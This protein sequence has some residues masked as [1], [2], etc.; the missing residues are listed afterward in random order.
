ME[1]TQKYKLVKF[2]QNPKGPYTI[3]ELSEIFKMPSNHI[4]KFIKYR[5]LLREFRIVP[6]KA[7]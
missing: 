7:D 3:D 6:V 2:G 4:M 1:N 5:M